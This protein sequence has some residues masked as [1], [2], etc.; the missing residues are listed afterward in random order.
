MNKEELELRITE[1]RKQAKN[2][3]LIEMSQSVVE[4]LGEFSEP[5]KRCVFKRERIQIQRNGRGDQLDDYMVVVYGGETVL[6]V[7]PGGM[8]YN[9][10]EIKKYIPGDWEAELKRLYESSKSLP[11]KPELR[12]REIREIEEAHYVASERGKWGL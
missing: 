7:S 10:G 11:S 5:H 8:N 3:R 2:R 1:R 4:R 9:L 12:D 6:H